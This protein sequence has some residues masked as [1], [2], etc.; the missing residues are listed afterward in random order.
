MGV[1]KVAFV[2]L[3]SIHQR[4]SLKFK[5]WND[6]LEVVQTTKYLGVQLTTSWIGRNTLTLLVLGGVF[7]P[8]PHFSTL[9]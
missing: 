2:G 8:L 4:E 1:K 6:E 7:R 5:I 3:T 9:H